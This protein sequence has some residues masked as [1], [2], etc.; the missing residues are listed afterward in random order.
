M[1]TAALTNLNG[2]VTGKALPTANRLL[3]R[4]PGRCRGCAAPVGERPVYIGAQRVIADGWPCRRDSPHWSD[5]R[6]GIFGKSAT[7]VR[8]RPVNRRAARPAVR[9][10]CAAGVAPRPEDLFDPQLGRS[11][12][13][14]DCLLESPSLRSSRITRALPSTESGT[15]NRYPCCSRYPSKS[16]TD[17]FVIPLRSASWL[18]Q[19]PTCAAFRS[20]YPAATTPA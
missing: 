5:R 14:I 2:V 18:G 13:G 8:G 17:C 11:S 12:L 1:D 6:R 10:S 3:A 9:A 16:L 19:S 7:G 4:L 20:S 15:R